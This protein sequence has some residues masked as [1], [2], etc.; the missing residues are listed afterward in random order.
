MN[1]TVITKAG[2]VTS[3]SEAKLFSPL[4]IRG[5]ELPNRVVISPMAMYAA[6]DGMPNDFHLVH[7]GKFVLGGAGTVFTGVV[8]IEPIGRITYGD[9]GIWDDAQI[10]GFKRITDFIKAK[11]GIAGIQL[12]HAGARASFQR[13]WHGNGFLNEI[14]EK[15]RGEVPWQLV[16]PVDE[17]AMPGAPRPQ[18]L[19]TDDI[20]A[21]LVKWRAAA[22]RAR[23]AGF[24]VLEIHGAHGY[25]IHEFLS[26]LS[27]NRTD[28]Y[29]GDLEGRMRFA[30]E[31]AQA[32][33]EEWPQDKPFFFRVSAV[34]ALDVGWSI[35]DTVALAKKLDAIG[36]DVIDCSSGGFA[37]LGKKHM[38][39]RKPG[40]Q[41]SFAEKVRRD[42][43]I[44]SMAV[45]LIIEARQAEE[46]LELG[47]ADLVCIGRE[48]LE[49]P[50]WALHAA[51][52]LGIDANFEKWP[53]EYGWWLERRARTM[54]RQAMEK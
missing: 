14:D 12:G 26:P 11:G 46:I 4:R 40:F 7:Y 17:P 48:A 49:N 45:G 27:N 9:L 19:T 3:T 2:N 22:R 25:L 37:V 24:D 38:L 43:S 30:L 54:A 15:A 39:P 36:V 35:D 20:A 44:M 10:P 8:A 53:P 34:D 21:M 52:S 6:T 41:V 50:N 29:G 23:Q 16:A 32:V 47:Q 51:R 1:T 5:V 33:R 31:V 18:A 42:A 13:P 28:A